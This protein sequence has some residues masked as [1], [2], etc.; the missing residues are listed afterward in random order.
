MAGCGGEGVHTNK[1][2]WK[3]RADSVI[4]EAVQSKSGKEGLLI[5]E[6]WTQGRRSYE[7]NVDSPP[8]EVMAY[9]ALQ[10][11]EENGEYHVV[12]TPDAVHAGD[13]SCK[14]DIK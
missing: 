4:L 11:Q 14:S 9:G 6:G 7:V 13:P 3:C 5:E 8:N 12:V 1:L 10:V 2:T